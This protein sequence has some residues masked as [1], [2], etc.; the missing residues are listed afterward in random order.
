MHSI[1]IEQLGPLKIFLISIHL[2]ATLATFMLPWAVLDQLIL[3]AIILASVLITLRQKYAMTIELNEHAI[4]HCSDQNNKRYDVTHMQHIVA[5]RCLITLQLITKQ[6]QKIQLIILPGMLNQ[7]MKKHFIRWLR[8][9][10][11]A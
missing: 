10:H 9:N 8:G 1:K 7:N 6:K 5:N 3:L 2:L 11:D 4:T